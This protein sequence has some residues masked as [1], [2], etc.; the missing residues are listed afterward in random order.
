MIV[1]RIIVVKDAHTGF[2]VSSD[3]ISKKKRIEDEGNL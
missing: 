3:L 1:F 2:L